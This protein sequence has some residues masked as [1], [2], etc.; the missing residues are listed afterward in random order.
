MLHGARRPS[1]R[2]ELL[3]RESVPL[4]ELIGVEGGS[5]E[6]AALSRLGWSG[7]LNIVDVGQTINWMRDRVRV[8]YDPGVRGVEPWPVCTMLFTSPTLQVEAGVK[9]W[10]VDLLSPLVVLDE[11]KTESTYSLPANTP[12]ISTVIALI[13]SSGETRIAATESDTT[14]N[15]ALVWA[16]GTPKL[17]IINDLLESAGYW[18][19]W[20][21]AAGQFRV[22]PYVA[23]SEREFA[24]EFTE[25]ETAIHFPEWGREQ[26]LASVPN[27]FVVVSEGSDEQPAIVGVAVN[28]DPESPYS[29][30]SRGRWVTDTEE[31][32]EV[33][34][35]AAANI[36]AQ[37]RLLDRMSPV[38]KVSA[39]H[40]LVPVAPNDVVRFVSD[41]Y[42]AVATVQRMGY[43]F[44]AA[45]VVTAEWREV[46][47]GVTNV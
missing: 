33:A 47:A 24:W 28:E 23:P 17:T 42:D 18:S 37:R 25:G 21:D 19:L 41:G 16:A 39:R 11:D 14:T 44:D 10:T 4:G 9:S 7:S 13:Q 12:I 15:A 5:C 35:Q 45:S 22:E 3:D 31:G 43:T 34:D 26:D 2:Y 27:R 20:C 36:L 38:A 29:Y 6:V 30:V 40:W 32:A 46:F 8:I 1:W